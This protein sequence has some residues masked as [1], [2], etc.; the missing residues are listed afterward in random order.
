MSHL[1]E[2][3]VYCM[4]SPYLAFI[5]R[6]CLY[7][8]G[9]YFMW[10][11]K[12]D[13]EKYRSW[14]HSFFISNFIFSTSF[15]LQASR[16]VPSGYVA[17]SKNC[18]LHFQSI[19]LRLDTWLT[20]PLSETAP[21]EGLSAWSTATY[22]HDT[23]AT[24]HLCDGKNNRGPLGVLFHSPLFFSCTLGGIVMLTQLSLH[25]MLSASVGEDC[26][27]KRIEVPAYGMK[28]VHWEF[29]KGICKW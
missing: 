16:W 2:I 19:P 15:F 3:T 8:W 10:K 18:R 9:C 13:A 27:S 25:Q 23:W 12:P 4:I 11:K 22:P 26:K 21:R 17:S 1:S 14:C 29:L 24:L 6:M 5:K 20:P 7:S 28:P